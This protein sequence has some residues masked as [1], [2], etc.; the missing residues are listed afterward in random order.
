MILS[1]IQSQLEEQHFR[2]V[3]KDLTRPS[4]GFF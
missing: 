2:I 3:D 4:D 1:L